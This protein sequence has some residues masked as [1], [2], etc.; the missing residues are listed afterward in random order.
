[1]PLGRPVPTCDLSQ[2][3]RD[4]AGPSTLSADPRKRHANHTISCPNLGYESFTRSLYGT[5]AHLLS[6]A[7]RRRG[8]QRTHASCAPPPIGTVGPCHVIFAAATSRGLRR[9][10]TAASASGGFHPIRSS[11]RFS[12]KGT[13]CRSFT[14]PGK[15][16]PVSR[17]V[18]TEWDPRLF[19]PSRRGGTSRHATSG[20]HFAP[21]EHPLAIRP[22]LTQTGAKANTSAE[23]VAIRGCR[24]GRAS[25]GDTPRVPRPRWKRSR[26]P[27]TPQVQ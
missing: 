19:V 22:H 17:V 5:V 7:S 9:S 1:M 21:T 2:G 3:D 20:C 13:A 23:T 26:R 16:W 25:G 18:S 11:S 14:K 10:P 27:T 6:A 15:R 4:A 8:R 24:R 12:F